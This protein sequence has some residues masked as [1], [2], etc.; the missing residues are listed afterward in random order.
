MIL[1][2]EEYNYYARG[3][4]K[5][6]TERGTQCTQFSKSQDYS[7]GL[8]QLNYQYTINS[9]KETLSVSRIYQL[10]RLVLT[11]SIVDRSQGVFTRC[12][13]DQKGYLAFRF[14]RNG[15]ERHSDG[16]NTSI[17]KD[18][19]IGIFDLCG[20]S[21]YQR[22]KRTEG[23]NLFIQQDCQ[24]EKILADST[25]SKTIDAQRGMGRELLEMI[26]QI[27]EQFSYCSEEENRL[28][29][30]H[31]LQIFCE[32]LSETA[33][34]LDSQNYNELLVSA[35][36]FMRQNL[37]DADLTI[38]Q[39]AEHCQTSI[40][41]LQ[42]VFQIADLSFSHYLNDLRLTAAAIRLY[43]TTS[44]VTAI[45]F[46][47]G[48]NNSSYFSKRFKEKYHLSP[49]RYRKKVQAMAKSNEAAERKCPLL[50]KFFP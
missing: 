14:I 8:S 48:Y 36:D 33:P 5:Q 6:M 21:H 11:H 24:T 35:T 39:T 27:A 44:P 34:F 50:E 45:A 2:P 10:D 26:F 37:Q 43:Q 23:I 42:K 7:N 15:F 47:C 1:A 25:T 19:T 3:A 18:Y 30:K 46:H 22:E 9:P 40:R 20:I 31:F 4:E 12:T 13:K 41:T 49:I 28:L 17:L 38:E 32:W 29:L 16:K